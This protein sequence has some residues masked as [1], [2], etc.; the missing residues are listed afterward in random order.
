LGLVPRWSG[1]RRADHVGEHLQRD[2]AAEA[3]G[4]SVTVVSA[5]RSRWLAVPSST[6]SDRTEVARYVE[7]VEDALAVE[8][9][10]WERSLSQ[11]Q[12]AF[13]GTTGRR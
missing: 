12:S 7:E 2:T 4:T 13:L 11:A 10:G 9:A 6:R 8:N 3:Y 1:N 5:V